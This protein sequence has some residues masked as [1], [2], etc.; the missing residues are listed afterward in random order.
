MR[1]F[2]KFLDVF[3]FVF[4]FIKKYQLFYN[5][6]EMIEFLKITNLALMDEAQLEFSKGF[7]VVTGE[8]GAGKSVLLGALSMLAGNRFGREIIK[9]GED[10]CKV[11]A[12][13]SFDDTSRFDSLLTDFGVAKCED[14]TL[15]LSRTISRT[16]SGRCF[17]NGSP[18]TLSAL[19][20]VGE[21][22]MDFHGPCEPQK[23]FST[24]NQLEMLDCFGVDSDLLSSYKA[25]YL[26]RKEVLESI[27]NLR[28]AKSLSPD[29][30]EFL[31][32]RISE[33]DALNPTDESV[34]ELENLSKLAE[35]ASCIVE[36]GSAI[37]AL[38]DGEDGAGERLCAANRLASDFQDAGDEAKLLVERLEAVTMEVSDIASDFEALARSSEM[39]DEE[40]EHIR[41]KMS[42]WLGLARKYGA[43][44]SM[45]RKAR[46]DMLERIE[47]QGDVDSTLK[48]LSEKEFEIAK[49]MMPLASKILASRKTS[50]KKLEDGVEEVL[51]KLGFKKASFKIKIEDKKTLDSF[52]GSS[53][54]FLFSANA[55]QS[56]ASLAK[57]ASSGEL[58]RVMLAI[59]TV[60]AEADATPILVFDEVDANVGGEIGVEVGAQL[61]GLATTH[62]VFC[63]THLPQV[64]S[65]GN[66]HFLV[67]KNQGEDSVK[68]N[69][70]RLSE[71]SDAR[72]VEL[73]RMLGDRHSLT[74]LSH[75]K[76]L[77]KEHSK[78]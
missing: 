28:N 2:K 70:S 47:N 67:E 32:K 78:K 13:F 38:L 18:V 19:S 59:K 61:A 34:A 11:E 20:A 7:S 74:A 16:K 10:T 58:A 1:F 75:A 6:G 77:L 56:P 21:R 37:S 33:I 71:N 4:C 29:E 35:K 64:A 23:L 76:K 40:I 62:Q 60:L 31:R 55:G 15:L 12:V 53:C 43:S 68:V 49:K 14:N 24:V 42:S 54:E 52:G 44:P 30:V 73:A 46:A 48:N 72:V 50:A 65:W 63:V 69:I 41:T 45:V 26:E 66:S 27:E 57:I 51:L 3:H 17:I 36:K 5:I 22:L 9:S 25:L 8:T 39:S